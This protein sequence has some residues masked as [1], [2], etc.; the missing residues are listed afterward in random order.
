MTSDGFE[1]DNPVLPLEHPSEAA[2]IMARFAADGVRSIDIFT[3]HLSPAVYDD[4]DLIAAI[5]ALAR[6]SRQSR[7]RLLVRNPF[8]LYGRDRPLLTLIQRLPS[9]AQIRVYSEGAKDRH[10]GFFCV[11]KKHLV[12]L[13]NEA[14]WRGFARYDARAESIHTLNEFEHLWLYGSYEDPNFRTLTL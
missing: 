12:Y 3:D 7:L 4:A 5:S 14:H 13:S 1:Q 6:R 11:D 9:R 10:M 2:P 8:P